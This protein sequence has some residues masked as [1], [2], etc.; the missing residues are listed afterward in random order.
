MKK[1]YLKPILQGIMEPDVLIIGAGAAGLIAA[2]ELSK[3]GKKVLILEARDRIGGRIFPLDKNEF[4]Y[5]AQGGAEFVHGEAPVTRALLKE[6][7]LTTDRN[8]DGQW[9][10]VIDGE[11]KVMESAAPY[12]PVLKEKLA[13]LAEDTT[14]AKFF[15]ENFAATEYDNLRRMTMRRIE[16]YY[17]GDPLRTSAFA[18]REDV[19]IE[20]T[21]NG[22]S[23]IKEGYG[24]MI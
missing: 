6:I 17:A 22:N 14:I 11:A 24:E 5:G 1:L 10:S 16:G 4:G 15:D 8:E 23:S 3:A 21:G 13:T 9:W 2:R 7:G 19:N 12:D 20:E 18:L